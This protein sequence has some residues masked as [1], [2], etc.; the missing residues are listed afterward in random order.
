MIK[1]NYVCISG[2]IAEEPEYFK[3]GKGTFYRAKIKRVFEVNG[4][5]HQMFVYIQGQTGMKQAILD[6]KIGDEVLVKGIL[7]CSD[8]MTVVHVRRLYFDDED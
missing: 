8:K 7:S 5:S 6:H 3:K 1:E 2:V 4:A